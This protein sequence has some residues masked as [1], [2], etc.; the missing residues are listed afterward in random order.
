MSEPRA[1]EKLL[2]S[3]SRITSRYNE[4]Q[5]VLTTKHDKE[6]AIALPF[7]AGLGLK[8]RSAPDIDTDL[9]GTFTGEI[10]RKGTP[11]ETAVK[12]ARLGMRQHNLPLGLASEGSF[13]PHPLLFYIPGTQ[14]FMVFVD[15]ELGIQITEQ[16]ISTETNYNSTSVSSVA[17]AEE[18]L[19]RVRFPS[20]GLIVRPNDYSPSLIEKA[21]RVLLSRKINSLIVKGVRTLAELE[22]AIVN[23]KAE[24]SDHMA[25]IETDMRAHMNPTR[26]RVIRT[27][28]I[29][30]ARRLQ[31][32]CPDCACP[33]FGLTDVVRGLPCSEC[34]FPSD[35]PKFEIHSCAKCQHKEQL[36][37]LDGLS[38]VDPGECHRCN[39]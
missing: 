37:R 31:K 30:L 17:D 38:Y 39:P 28:A 15:D 16:I 8:V 3:G 13:G 2:M 1:K 9:L 26:Q 7:Q 34:G 36:A 19:A 18:F 23:C 12:K 4:R 29:K 35:S 22:L 21:G 24:S 27:L 6:K 32:V 25:Y 33:G 14:E 20:H 11:V 5:V 10:E